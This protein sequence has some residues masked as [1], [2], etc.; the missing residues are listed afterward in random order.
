M[1]QLIYLTFTAPRADPI[2][3][4]G[5]AVEDSRVPLAAQSAMLDVRGSPTRFVAALSQN[6]P[7]A[8]PMTPARVD[9]MNLAKPARLLP[10]SFR[11]R[12]AGLRSSS[13][14][15]SSF[16]TLKPLVE[17]HSSAAF[18][19]LHRNEMAKDTGIRPPP[20]V[21]VK[22]VRRGI[23]PKSEVGIVFTGAFENDEAHRV[24][25][26]RAMA[27]MLSGDLQST[28]REVLGG[29]YGVEVEPRFGDRPGGGGQYRVSITFG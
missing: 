23:E 17:R 24:I 2:A 22:E 11:R 14:A 18:P 3:F 5:A 9:Q 20:G 21:V 27:A 25:I 12:R 8:Q 7:R 6:H 26:V 29:T 1:F 4:A 28:L 16:A 15:A 19:A 10:R 13:S